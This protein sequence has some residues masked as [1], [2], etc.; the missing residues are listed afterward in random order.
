MSETFYAFFIINFEFLFL[1]YIFLFGRTHLFLVYGNFFIT[2]VLPQI[3]AKI[4]H[5]G[6]LQLVFADKEVY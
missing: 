4:I 2:N 3:M 5:G 1:K 6:Q